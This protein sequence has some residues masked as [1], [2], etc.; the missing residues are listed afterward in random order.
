M[1]I[2]VLCLVRIKIN[3]PKVLSIA[4]R[5]SPFIPPNNTYI[6]NPLLL[7]LFD[8]DKYDF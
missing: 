3:F 8:K 2:M 4:S 5:I 6:Y 7:C 1:E